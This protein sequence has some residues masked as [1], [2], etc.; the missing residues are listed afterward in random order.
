MRV[1]SP[2]LSQDSEE[3]AQVL[4]VTSPLQLSETGGEETG[5]EETGGEETGDVAVRI[6]QRELLRDMAQSLDRLLVGAD[7]DVKVA[8]LKG[9]SCKKETLLRMM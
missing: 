2:L 6:S 5:G 7:E 9:R 4:A 8:T 1:T 3:I